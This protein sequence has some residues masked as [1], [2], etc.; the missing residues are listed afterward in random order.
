MQYIIKSLRHGTKTR[1]WY[2]RDGGSRYSDMIALAE[3]YS[4]TDAK[5]IQKRI[6]KTGVELIPVNK[7]LVLEAE[8]Q[9]QR[10]Q[11]LAQTIFQRCQSATESLEK[12]ANAANETDNGM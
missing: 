7:G 1:P 12:L 4:D 11:E 10:D 9:I 3:I 5:V 8:Q 6:G 2:L